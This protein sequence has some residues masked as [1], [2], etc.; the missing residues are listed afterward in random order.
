M[1]VDCHGEGGNYSFKVQESFYE[2]H[3]VDCL[4]NS[5]KQRPS[6]RKKNKYGCS[7]V[8]VTFVIILYYWTL[9][10]PLKFCFWVVMEA[11][12]FTFS[13]HCVK[14]IQMKRNIRSNI[15]LL[16][17]LL[18]RGVLL[19]PCLNNP[20]IAVYQISSLYRLRLLLLWTLYDHSNIANF[21]MAASPYVTL[22]FI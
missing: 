11:P 13:N 12:N 7:Y 16:L 19:I 15:K 5:S 18:I 20:Y 8:I 17:R 6:D 3:C 10:F 9:R 4:I 2:L 22:N 14:N 1:L 21:S